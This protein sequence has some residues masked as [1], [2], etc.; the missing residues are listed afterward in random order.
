MKV[1]SHLYASPSK[2]HLFMPRPQ[3]EVHE[4]MQALEELAVSYDT[5]DREIESIATEKQLLLE[6]MEQLQVC[7]VGP[8]VLTEVCREIGRG[9]HV[10]QGDV[11]PKT[12][13]YNLMFV[14]ESIFV[15]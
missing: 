6:E 8:T 4:V 11:Y 13:M 3:D 10:I 12:Y 5:K 1:P 15:L 2:P 9:R 14:C 7:L